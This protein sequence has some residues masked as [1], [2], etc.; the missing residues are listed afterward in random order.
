MKRRDFVWGAGAALGALM[1]GG[2]VLAERERDPAGERH[3]VRLLER[4]R[5]WQIDALV[6]T[7]GQQALQVEWR[8]GAPLFLEDRVDLSGLN[9]ALGDVFRPPFRSR[10]RHAAP[11]GTVELLPGERVLVARV[12][13]IGRLAGARATLAAGDYSWDL[14]GILTR[15]AVPGAGRAVGAAR[16]ERNGALLLLLPQMVP[17]L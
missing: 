15:G 14:P 17:Q 11:I 10:W 5:A 3:L 9:G 1:T 16:A 7:D 2:P 12:A 8:G 4:G 13:E 6:V